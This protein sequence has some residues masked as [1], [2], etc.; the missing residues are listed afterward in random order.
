[1]A[2]DS[3]ASAFDTIMDFETGLDR[4]DLRAL[5][6]TSTSLSVG[7]G[8]TT[9][10]ATSASGTLVVR[11]TGTASLSD[12]VGTANATIHGSAGAETLVGL[13]MQSALYGEGG[14]DFIVGGAG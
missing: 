11:I 7:A 4:I 14:D 1:V 3:T 10:T 8:F 12:L 2:S 13:P 5:S 6:P 9:L